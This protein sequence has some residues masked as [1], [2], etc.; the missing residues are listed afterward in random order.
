MEQ[1]SIVVSQVAEGWY[2]LQIDGCE[3]ILV[4]REALDRLLG[5]V[6]GMDIP[7]Y[8]ALATE[9]PRSFHDRRS[10]TEDQLKDV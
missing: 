9:E 8:N 7:P 1:Q 2:F 4:R 10:V 5:I 3:S 6:Y